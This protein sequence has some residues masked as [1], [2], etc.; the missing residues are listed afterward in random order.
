[1]TRT[2][3]SSTVTALIAP[4][5]Y[6]AWVI[7]LDIASDPVYIN[8]SLQDMYFSAGAGIDPAI[9]GYTFK[10]L[11]NV[12]SIDPITD[13]HDGS[14]TV[15]ITV[16]GVDLTMD[17]L[18]QI[19]NNADIWQRKRAYIWLVTLD[20]TG[21]IVGKPIRVKSGLIDQMPISIDPDNNTGTLVASIESQQA[22]SGEALFSR[23][24]EQ[25]QI[26]STDT[27]QNYVADLANKVPTIGAKNSNT[28]GNIIGP[29]TGIN[30]T[31]KFGIK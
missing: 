5:L 12:A 8:T 31:Q 7:R 13:S 27:S 2:I 29:L 14:Q 30:Y 26:D 6:P 15:N 16:P 28:A 25:N 20:A 10:G 18:H 21:A 22:Y 3:D 4:T 9:V 11:G 1:M 24:S 19:I 17:Y 23:Y